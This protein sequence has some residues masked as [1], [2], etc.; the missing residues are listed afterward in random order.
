MTCMWGIPFNLRNNTQFGMA[1]SLGFLNRRSSSRIAANVC[2][3]LSVKFIDISSGLIIL[4][5]YAFALAGKES[6]FSAGPRLFN[7]FLVVIVNRAEVCVFYFC[8]VTRII[9]NCRVKHG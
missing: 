4:M 3:E 1:L 5:S 7:F 2:H 6:I 9:G 8:V